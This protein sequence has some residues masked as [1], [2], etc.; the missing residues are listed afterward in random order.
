[1]S[2]QFE[3]G[4]ESWHETHFE[5]VAMITQMRESNNMPST[6][7]EINETQGTGGF[8]E[9]AYDLTNEFEKMH[10]GRAWDGDFFDEIEAFLQS[11]FS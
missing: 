6:L 2:K 1:M 4:F 10:S 9:L 7:I 5:V 8:Y 3:N 11:K